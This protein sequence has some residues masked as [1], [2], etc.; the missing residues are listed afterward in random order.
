MST[1]HAAPP[2][3]PECGA[4][5]RSV[6]DAFAETGLFRLDE[7]SLGTMRAGSILGGNVLDNRPFTEASHQILG[8]D[9][10]MTLSVFTPEGG[11]SEAPGLF[12]IHGGGMVLGD[13]FLVGE[14]LD[15]A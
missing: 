5:W 7:T 15:A 9:G 3:D 12:W 11:A 10:E 2:F 14:A 8:S 13:R 1:T 6:Y 4:V